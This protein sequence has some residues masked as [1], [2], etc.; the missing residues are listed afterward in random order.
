MTK[1]LTA[2]IDKHHREKRIVWDSRVVQRLRP[3]LSVETVSL[4]ETKTPY[5][6]QQRNKQK[7]T[8]AEEA[9]IKRGLGIFNLVLKTLFKSLL[10]MTSH[11][12]AHA[13]WTPSS[14]LNIAPTRLF[15]CLLSY[16][17]ISFWRA[18]AISY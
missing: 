13:R 18:E 9:T 5:A 16:R 6:M 2:T 7:K 17:I 11:C 1:F 12:L 3:V 4:L 10:L 8:D 14:H 15:P